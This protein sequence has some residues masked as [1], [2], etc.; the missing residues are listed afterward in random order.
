MRP[1]PVKPKAMRGKYHQGAENPCPVI[2]DILVKSYIDKS[3]TGLACYLA[4]CLNPL[5]QGLEEV[6]ATSNCY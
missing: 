6:Y 2:P 5:W 4:D 1:E 3:P